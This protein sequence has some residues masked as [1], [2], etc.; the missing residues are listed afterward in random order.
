MCIQFNIC[1]NQNYAYRFNRLKTRVTMKKKKRDMRYYISRKNKRDFFQFFISHSKIEFFFSIFH[2]V[3]KE[4]R[5]FF[6]FSFL[7]E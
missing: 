5:D 3:Y 4:K 2:F 1:R 6:Q 7:H